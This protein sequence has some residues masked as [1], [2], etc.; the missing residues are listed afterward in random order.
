MKFNALTCFKKKTL[1]S[2]NLYFLIKVNMS[3]HQVLKKMNRN[4]LG[5]AVVP[6]VNQLFTCV[7]CSA[8]NFTFLVFLSQ[9]SN[10]I[11]CT[12]ILLFEAC[13][14]CTRTC[15]RAISNLPYYLLH[16]YIET[17][18]HDFKIFTNL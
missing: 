10:Y 4:R 12:H 8:S 13:N 9:T 18:D 3:I 11:H 14:G 16:N 1:K 6:N 17:L 2:L 5:I 7:S 15:F